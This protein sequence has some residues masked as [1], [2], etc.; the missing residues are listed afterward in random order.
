MKKVLSLMLALAMLFTMGTVA[1]AADEKPIT[2]NFVIEGELVKSIQVDYGEDY[3]SQAPDIRREISNGIKY[4]FG[5]WETTNKYYGGTI[6]EKLPVIEEG[7]PVYEITFT[8]TYTETEYDGEEIAS[9]I[10]GDNTVAGFKTI[11]ASFV[12][13]LQ[14]VLL[15]IAAF[16]SF[17]N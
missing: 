6:Y 5:G 11:W 10:L 2:I 7:T 9:D 1:F 13:F 8:A 17:G 4:E 16:I 14:Q 3:N 15:Y 12:E